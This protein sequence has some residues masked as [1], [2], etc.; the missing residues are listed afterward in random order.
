MK[1]EMINTIQNCNAFDLLVSMDGSSVNLII[2][3]GEISLF[4]GIIRK[5][6]EAFVNRNIGNVKKI[7]FMEYMCWP[8]WIYGCYKVL[9][10]YGLVLVTSDIADGQ[11]IT[12]K[13][14]AVIIAMETAG[15]FLFDRIVLYGFEGKPSTSIYIFSKV[16][17]RKMMMMHSSRFL[18]KKKYLLESTD[19]STKVIFESRERSISLCED[20]ISAYTAKGDTVLD[21]FAGSG[22]V[23]EAAISLGRNY[24]GSEIDEERYGYVKE[25]IDKIKTKMNKKGGCDG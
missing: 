21:L 24:I 17:R 9:D 22:V 18:D 3:D 25:R 14:E 2:L 20:L 6:E 19:D 7:I 23:G 8:L 12:K 5:G 4:L 13:R 16:Q 10:E 15:F 1:K 11:D